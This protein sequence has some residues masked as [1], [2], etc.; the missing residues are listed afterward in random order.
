MSH[1]YHKHILPNI[2]SN[3]IP[4]PLLSFMQPNLPVLIQ[5]IEAL[6]RSEKTA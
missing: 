3:R 1:P 2:K 4:A 5:E 6:V